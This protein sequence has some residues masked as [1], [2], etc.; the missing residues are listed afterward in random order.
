MPYPDPRELS[1]ANVGS[2]L[3][4]R[5]ATRDLRSSVRPRPAL[6][7]PAI[8]CWLRPPCFADGEAGVRRA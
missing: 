1:V 3:R 5:A 7:T 8:H 2:N 6:P 4:P